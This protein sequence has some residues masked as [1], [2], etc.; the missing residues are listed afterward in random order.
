[1]LGSLAR[2]PY[3]G[4]SSPSNWTAR[5]ITFGVSEIVGGSFGNEYEIAFAEN[6]SLGKKV[7]VTDG[8][9]YVIGD[10]TLKDQYLCIQAGEIGFIEGP[11]NSENVLIEFAL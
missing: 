3:Q 8:Y 2:E 11:P 9:L 1:M 4:G 7:A 6:L 10:H 5:E